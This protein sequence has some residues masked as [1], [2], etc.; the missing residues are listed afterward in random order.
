[1]GGGGGEK[2]RARLGGKS[3]YIMSERN[4]FLQVNSLQSGR[5][6]CGRG[7]KGKRQ[8]ELRRG[9]GIQPALVK[10][11]ECSAGLEKGAIVD[12]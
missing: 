10:G 7:S 8:S 6:L 11:G 5:V 2:K 12:L 1:V 3:L 4:I 9:M